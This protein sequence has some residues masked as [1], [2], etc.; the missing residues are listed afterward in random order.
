MMLSAES[1]ATER[2]FAELVNE[3]YKSYAS[4]LALSRSPLAH[5]SLVTPVL[6]FD[7]LTP[8]PEERGRGLQ[9]LLCWALEKTAP[10]SIAYPLGVFRPWND[11]TWRDPAWWRYTILRHR[12]VEP[13][14]PDDFVEGGRYTETLLAL[15]GIPNTDAFFAERNRAIRE[16]ASILQ[17]QME[18]NAAGDELQQRMLTLVY[19]PLLHRPEMAQLLK[20][21][22]V[23]EGVFPR[24]LLTM[25]AEAE[26]MRLPVAVVDALVEERFILTGDEGHNLWL[27]PILRAY[28]YQH[29]E[30]SRLRMRHE[31]VA[32]YLANQHEMLAAAHHYR[33]AGQWHAAADLLLADAAELASD[34]QSAT[35]R[36]E[37]AAFPSSALDDERWRRIQ[38]LLSDLCAAD[39]DHDAAID[40]CRAA[41]KRTS[42]PVEQGILFRR[43]G[44]LYEMRNQMHALN[45]YR[46]AEERLGDNRAE[47][48]ILLKDR[49]WLHIHRR[50]WESAAAD[51]QRARTLAVDAPDALRADV[52]DALAALYRYQQ[53][54][55]DAIKCAQQ[56][57]ALRE[58]SG[59]LSG[60]AKSLGNLGLLYAATGAYTQASVAHQEARDLSQRL[61]NRE[62]VATATLNIGLAH[63]LAGKLTEA[64]GF[65]RQSLT[66]CREIKQRLVELR[67]LSNLT[68]ALA[69]LGDLT[70]AQRYWRYALELA[71]RE[72]FDDEAAY[73]QELAERF[74]FAGDAQAIPMAVPVSAVK[75]LSPGTA[76]DWTA[77]DLLDPEDA[78][79]LDLARREGKVTPRR[80]MKAASLSKAT[81]TRR[82]TALAAAG[83]LLPVGR[84]RGTCYV[85]GHSKPAVLS[86]DLRER[87]AILA[88]GWVVGGSIL[89]LRFAVLPDLLTFLALRGEVRR[90]FGAAVEV[91][92][93][94]ALPVEQEVVWSNSGSIADFTENLV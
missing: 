56:G 69:E 61:G 32:A 19:T 71:R 50:A 87:Y 33:L 44:K 68:E 18:S 75:T 86:D 26:Q 45:Y 46:Q 52:F 22:A 94:E 53:A 64:V 15:T 29:E 6:V 47:L 76:T 66:L 20:I 51:L 3:A 1:Q 9:L 57:L 27:S 70:A 11:P 14:H 10:A 31:R 78:L 24:T 81:A 23:I 93:E 36:A 41:F 34:P 55:D 67:S 5:S 91:L 42:A 90:Q 92:P 88:A 77:V 37:L 16:A 25:L 48:V 49:G 2:Q 7:P 62:M 60:V 73:L 72:S 8:T 82:L 74:G 79:V 84:G 21:A 30:Q 59:D 83:L 40:A 65:Y 58:Q 38:T 35:V 85:V 28:L 12:Y 80:L 54:F 63:H 13:L 4:I 89:A 17:Q 39:G 43:I